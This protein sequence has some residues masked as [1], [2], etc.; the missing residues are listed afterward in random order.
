MN[1]IVTG[2]I[3]R[4]GRF[5]VAHL[6]SKGHDIR[7]L[8]RKAASDIPSDVLEMIQGADYHQVDITNPADLRPHF[9]ATD[10]VVHLAAI[11]FPIPDK[12]A[13]IFDVNCS[14][15]F[16]VYQ[17]AADAGVQRVV[18]ASSINALGNGFGVRPIPVHYFPID[19]DHPTWTSDVYSFSK[20][21]I[22]ETAAY[23]WRRKAIT[24]VCM[25]F[26]WVYSPEQMPAAERPAHFKRIQQEYAALQA[27]SP[28][29]REAAMETVQAQYEALRRQR[30]RGEI[31]YPTMFQQMRALPY[32]GFF[33]GRKDFWS[34]LDVRDAAR[35]IELAVTAAYEGSHV[36]HI[37]DA[38]NS[39]G[40]P[41]A[42]LVAIFYPEVTTWKRPV[43]GAE[44]LFS[45][46]RARAL[47]GYE[48]QHSIHIR[49]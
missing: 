41:T 23:F 27:M 4:I 34:I 21:V 25:R 39:T 49:R 43:H 45:I 38:Y 17:A 31:D 28:A 7:I 1:I 48:P 29:E 12:D 46:E 2:G 19:E 30:S 24:G 11:P 3:G 26:P 22:E 10:A 15:T 32:R 35:A 18:S 5:T 6:R 42:E 37:A 8:D 33:V 13:E 9:D 14:G 20:Q 16:N 36:L 44:A 40:L 47:I